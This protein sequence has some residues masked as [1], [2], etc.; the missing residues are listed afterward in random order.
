MGL[1]GFGK[2]KEDD[3]DSPEETENMDD[4]EQYIEEE[5]KAVST[6]DMNIPVEITR[7]KA[8]VESLGELR[9]S[10]Q[11]RFSRVSNIKE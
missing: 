10:T 2:K 3:G 7:L 1:F 8:Q 6:E 4:D 5:T 11:E 9:K